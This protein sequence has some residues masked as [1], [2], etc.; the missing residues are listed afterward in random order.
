MLFIYLKINFFQPHFKYHPHKKHYTPH[1]FSLREIVSLSQK[2]HQKNFLLLKHIIV[3]PVRFRAD[4]T[5]HVGRGNLPRRNLIYHYRNNHLLKHIG[6]IIS[7][8]MNIKF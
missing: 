6:N 7:Q 1:I 5:F 2:N 3:S 8:K 4:G